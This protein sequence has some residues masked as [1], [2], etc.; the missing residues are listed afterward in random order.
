MKASRKR[1][2]R[3]QGRFSAPARYLP[4]SPS[5]A[6]RL[7]PLDHPAA[8]LRKRH[9]TSTLMRTVLGD[10]IS[11]SRESPIVRSRASRRS[12]LVSPWEQVNFVSPQLTERAQIC[13][14]RAIRRE[15]LFAIKGTGKGSGARRRYS[16][17][18][19]VRC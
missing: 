18:S 3:A 5:V 1:S 4:T 13:A 2:N 11:G 12:R 17:K 9:S 7:G 16:E 14:R 6:A 19:K 10:R 8:T 15:V